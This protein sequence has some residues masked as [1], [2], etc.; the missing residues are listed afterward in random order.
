[1]ARP[2]TGELRI[3]RRRDGATTYSLRF[4][5]EGKRHNVRL[6][7]D[8]EGWTQRRAEVELRNTL[9]K[10]AAGIWRPAVGERDNHD[11]P[12]TFHVFASNWLT[13]RR[14][15]LRENSYKDYRWRLVDHL[16]PFFADH[17]VEDID[18]DLVDRYREHK[19][20]EREE[21]LAARRAGVELRDENDRP[22][23]GL[24]NESINKTLMLLGS[25][26]EDGVERGLLASNPAKGKRR[27]L[28][29]NSPSRPFLEADELGSLIDAG[30]AIDRPTATEQAGEACRLRREGRTFTEIAR[31]L[32]MTTSRAHYL[33]TRNHPSSDQG[34]RF[35]RRA[36]IATLGCAGLRVGE[37]CAL[38][39]RHVDFTHR[40]LLV[41]AAKTDAG[42]REVDMTPRL[43]DELLAYRASLGDV[44]PVAPVFPTRAGARRDK[45]N[46][47]N[48]VLAPAV[49]RADEARRQ[50]GLPALPERLTPHALRRT[51]ISLML[52]AG[53]SIPYVMAQ[54]GHTSPDV[55]LRIYAQVLNRSRRHVGAAFDQLMKDAVEPSADPARD[56][57]NPADAA[58]FGP[59]IG[60]E[61]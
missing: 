10:V 53:A 46:V 35:V 47:R 29:P 61:S 43:A 52:E 7:S 25:M 49:R 5:V 3:H 33:V 16:L 48:R 15:E 24:S 58:A 55:T 60:P 44:D 59:V 57:Q 56:V 1:M 9:A 26:L 12:A 4:R 27:R 50:R 41:T 51:Y 28:K 20:L 38:D 34:A 13:R 23:R 40:R 18:I 21:I 17:A 8:E 2:P 54:V 42:A 45:D 30:E 32:G 36:I 14:H 19:V 11:Q 31:T 39:W 6:G 37:L 22:R